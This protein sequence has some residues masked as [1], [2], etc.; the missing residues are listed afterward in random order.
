[1]KKTKI[2]LF[3][4]GLIAGSAVL[5][6]CNGDNKVAEKQQGTAST[7][8]K[9]KADTNTQEV[10]KTPVKTIVEGE[11]YEVLKTPLDIPQTNKMVISE[12][13]WLGCGHCQ[14]FDPLVHK[15]EKELVK[16]TNGVEIIKTAAPGSLELDPTG[17]IFNDRWTYDARVFNALKQLGGTD[18]D[19]TKMLQLYNKKAVDTRSFPT[20]DDVMGYFT[21]LG[22]DK[23]KA[24]ELMKNNDVMM[25]LLK[26]ANV[27]F[28]KTGGQGTPVFVVDGIYK[29]KF[30]N[31]KSDADAIALFEQLHALKN[32]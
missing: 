29:V 5:T 16:T 2:A 13:F 23:D 1:M 7:I 18:A 10:A 6:G 4:V 17:N 25:P 30:N 32:K 22:F 21:Q 19:V 8:V 24:L 26:K 3:L 27:E 15:W 9:D 11:D 20:P 12:F 14:M 31:V 28:N